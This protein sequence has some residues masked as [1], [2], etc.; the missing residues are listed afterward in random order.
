MTRARR[1]YAWTWKGPPVE[2]CITIYGEGETG[3]DAGQKCS[4][5]GVSRLRCRFK[6]GLYE[7][8]KDR[9][10]GERGCGIAGGGHGGSAAKERDGG[11]IRFGFGMRVYEGTRETDQPRMRGGLRKGRIAAGD[12]GER[13]RDLLA[14]RFGDASEGAE[15]KARGVCGKSRQGNRQAV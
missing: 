1:E 14:D 13:W 9:G 4:Q 2:N 5:S 8:S 10:I 11:R 6:R 7:K 3:K 15:R 12:T